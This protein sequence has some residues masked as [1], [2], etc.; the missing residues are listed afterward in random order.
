MTKYVIISGEA[1]KAIDKNKL[2]FLKKSQQ[3]R[4]KGNF[5]QSRRISRKK[6]L[7]SNTLNCERVTIYYL[8]LRKKPIMNNV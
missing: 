7:I 8:R 3:S 1:E 5:S 6:S 2:H 4:N